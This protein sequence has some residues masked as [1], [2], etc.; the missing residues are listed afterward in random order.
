MPLLCS[1][2]GHRKKDHTYSV[3]PMTLY[4]NGH[5]GPPVTATFL[6]QTCKRKGCRWH[7][8]ET[9]VRRQIGVSTRSSTH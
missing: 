9:L 8:R 2:L 3:G 6:I 7:S 5:C 4:K 1:L